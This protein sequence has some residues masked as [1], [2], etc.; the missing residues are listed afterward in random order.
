M[1]K[2]DDDALVGTN[3]VVAAGQMLERIVD[4]Q[5]GSRVSWGFQMGSTADLEDVQQARGAMGSVL[6]GVVGESAD[7]LFS[8]VFL[9][10]LDDSDADLAQLDQ[11]LGDMKKTLVEPT[12][13][14]KD[15][16]KM[17]GAAIADAKGIFVITWGNTT[18]WVRSRVL[19]EYSI[20][21]DSPDDDVG[22]FKSD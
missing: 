8:V 21:V 17:Y 4:V 10:E 14:D 12:S 11:R 1:G 19:K 16:G 6:D 15:G 13:V 9:K 5:G 7:M 3:K 22:S 18:S 20:I 2:D